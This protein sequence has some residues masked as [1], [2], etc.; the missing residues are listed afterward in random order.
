MSSLSKIL[1]VDDSSAIHHTYQVTL[2]RYKCPVLTVLNGQE[3]LDK[4]TQN[5]DVNLLIIDMNMQPRM[6][7][8][9]FIKKVKEQKAFNE[10][11]IIAVISRENAENSPEALQL[12]EG[13]LKKP[14]TS[15]E[16]H[17]VVEKIFPQA[18]SESKT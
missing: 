18:I 11:P 10:I 16:I 14:F 9:E 4:L 6:S 3:G 5:P 7:G 1:V 2:A 13:V 15:T 12:A 17:K 8:V